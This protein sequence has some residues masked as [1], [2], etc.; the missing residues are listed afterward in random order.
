MLIVCFWLQLLF[1]HL[2]VYI[3]CALLPCIL[4][5]FPTSGLWCSLNLVWVVGVVGEYVIGYNSVCIF[6]V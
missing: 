5:C 4:S 1:C 3:V 6:G 2:D